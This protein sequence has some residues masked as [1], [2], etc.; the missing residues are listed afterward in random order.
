METGRKYLAIY[1]VLRDRCQEATVGERLASER[2]L[3]EEFRVSVMTVRQA[4]ARLA[5][6][7][8]VRRSA[9]SGTFVARPTVSM[10]PTLT[11]FTEDMARRGLRSRSEVRRLELLEP[12]LDV[13]RD[14]DLRPGERVLLLERLRFAGSDPMCH[15][16][17]LFPERLAPALQE[18]DLTGSTHE[19]LAAHGAVPR[20][21]R[22]TVRAV[23]LP[24]AQSALLGLPDGAPA[25]EIL[26]VF[27]DTLGRPM[28]HARSRYRFDRY[29]VLS[30]IET[31]GR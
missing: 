26:D 4:L 16:V 3:A 13:V 5:D 11:S 19:A 9:G 18:A 8:W 28:Q 2:A 14:L 24:A 12:G 31:P 7:G 27:T 10:G 15:E 20:S 25:L 1:E 29:E 30:T 21:T 17:A 6:D 23:V 22:R